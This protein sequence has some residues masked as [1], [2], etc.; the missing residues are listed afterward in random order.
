MRQAIASVKSELQ[1]YK[2]LMS[3]E[4][5]RVRAELKQSKERMESELARMDGQFA[6]HDDGL[7]ALRIEQARARG[8]IEW[9][10]EN[11]LTRG[12][13]QASMNFLIGR[14]DAFLGK[15]DDNRYHVAKQGERLDD[16]EKRLTRIETDRA[17]SGAL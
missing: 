14:F 3:A 13:F 15:W 4:S 2:E 1:L 10:K 17:S 5:S 11:M 16:H 6:A 12:E 9:L 7:R 8:D